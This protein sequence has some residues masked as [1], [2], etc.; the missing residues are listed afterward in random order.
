LHSSSHTQVCECRV[1]ISDPIVVWS[2]Y[3]HAE[4]FLHLYSPRHHPITGIFFLRCFHFN[5]IVW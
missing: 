5:Y 4:G 1:G 2:P 3:H